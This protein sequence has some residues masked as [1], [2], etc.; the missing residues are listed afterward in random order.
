[1]GGIN[2]NNIGQEANKTDTKDIAQIEEKRTGGAIALTGFSYQCLYSTY[3][4]LD[5]VTS[6]S[7]SIRF[8]GIEDID[9][10]N[11]KGSETKN[12]I[13]VKFSKKQQDA[14]HMKDI[15]KNFLEVY[16]VNKMD[17]SRYY[18]LVYD[19]EVANGYLKKIFV[20]KTDEILDSNAENYWAGVIHKIQKDYPNWNWKGFNINNFFS[21]LRFQKIERTNLIELIQSLLIKR[22]NIDSGNEVLY[23]HSLF[24]FC[25]SKMVERET[26]NKQELDKYILEISDAINKGYKNPAYQWLRKIEFEKVTEATDDKYFEGKKATP[27]DII[28]GYPVDRHIIENNTKESIKHNDITVIKAASGQGKTTLAWKVL[29]ELK[30]SYSIYNLTWCNERKELNNL[31]QFIKSRIK[32][33]EIPL[34]LL[35]NL[36]VELNEWNYLAQLLEEEIGTNYRILITTRE[37]DWF[38]YAGDQSSIKR[39]KLIEIYLSQEEAKDIFLS[40]N[41]NN[42]LDSSIINWESSWEEIRDTGLLI[43]YVYLLTQGE[44]LSERI[45][46]QITRIASV[47]QSGIKYDILSKICLA[48]TMGVLVTRDKLIS[49][50]QSKKMLNITQALNE[51]EN[52]YFIKQDENYKYLSGVH[53]IRSQHILDSISNFS[54]QNTIIDLLTL[55]DNLYISPLYSNIPFYVHEEKECFYEEIVHE[56]IGY[57]Y[58]F[59]LNAIRGLF[60]GSILHYYQSNKYYFNKANKLGGLFLFSTEVNPYSNFEGFNEK[61]EVLS[62]LAEI[63][64]N[65]TNIQSLIE[66][67]KEIPIFKIKKADYYYYAHYLSYYLKAKRKLNKDY[68]STL[69]YWLV[70]TDY[71]FVLID[72]DYMNEVWKN[73][74]DWLIDSFA[75]LMLAFYLSD[76][77]E[78]LQFLEGKKAKILEYLTMKTN[79][80]KI[81][82]NINENSLYVEYILIP[83]DII[84]GNE[85]SV[86][87]LKLLCKSLPIYDFYQAESIQP[88]IELLEGYKNIDESAKNMP[89]R[90][91][92]IMFHQEF[93]KMWEN[94]IIENYEATT[95]FDWISYWNNIRKDIINLFQKNIQVIDRKLNDRK[96]SKNI[97]TEINNIRNKIISDLRVEYPYP[98]K[99]RPFEKSKY[100]PKGKLKIKNEYFSSVRNYINQ[101]AGFVGRDEKN[102]RLAMFNLLYA[103]NQLEEMQEFYEQVIKSSGHQFK[104]DLDLQKKETASIERLYMY[105]LY[106]KNHPNSRVATYSMI[107]NWYRDYYK[108]PIVNLKAIIETKKAVEIKITYPDELIEK[109]SLNYLPLLVK[110][111][112]LFSDEYNGKLIF[113]MLPALD[114]NIDFI[115]V[116]FFEECGTKVKEQ[117]IRISKV[118]LEAVKNLIEEDDDTALEKQNPPV[119]LEI[120]KS[121]LKPFQST[122]YEIKKRS[123]DILLKYELL[124]MNL[125]EYS[126]FRLYV[127]NENDQY[128]EYIDRKYRKSRRAVNELLSKLKTSNNNIFKKAKDY[129]DSVFNDKYV[130]GDEDFNEI[131]FE[132]V[133][134]YNANNL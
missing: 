34:V 61:L 95:V 37:E 86:N 42:R 56:T 30:D 55:V 14:S 77:E 12:H 113:S 6:E 33:G 118:Y 125:W 85:A 99:K 47:D 2:L 74:Y 64:P 124:F 25:F 63:H 38:H 70:N 87:R 29:Y 22:Y 130:F 69:N 105:N 121:Y 27:S 9:M 51:M 53:P 54:E 131:Y 128:K 58:E 120:E 101:M 104:K 65:D 88:K 66:L 44:M 8:E 31:V 68:F 67:S 122:Y 59:H 119:P 126:Q 26:M 117:G 48:D 20:K 107:D 81:Q 103:K 45:E 97:F 41:K 78:Y 129:S 90:N 46:S 80:V 40:L 71:S 89:K 91:I 39:L 110:N 96:I 35:D 114:Y 49:F 84:K 115:I 19:Y 18:T 106:Y 62:K 76:K 36:N 102:S 72:K 10:Y 43:E 133:D 92:I 7:E 4:L 50:Y 127:N 28:S 79:S 132:L 1:M 83:T 134:N 94:T 98:G 23:G 3:I 75:D 5:K 123:K 108:T 11:F 60:S 116:M 100:P 52:E 17:E 111:A 82:E 112:D 57:S 109:D 16:L 32:A 73:R 21:Q 24:S 93:A 13:Q 15:L